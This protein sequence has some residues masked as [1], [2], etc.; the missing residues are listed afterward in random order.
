M[1]DVCR[2]RLG[3]ASCARDTPR[4]EAPTRATR[5][6][7][8]RLILMVQIQ[9]YRLKVRADKT[10]RCREL[11]MPSECRP[12]AVYLVEPTHFCHAGRSPFEVAADDTPRVLTG[13]TNQAMSAKHLSTRARRP[14]KSRCAV[15]HRR[16]TRQVGLSH[17]AD[18][19]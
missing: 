13:K 11:V 9:I 8:T 14:A 7:W 12:L 15:P 18:S 16:R 5:S 2:R 19:R 6:Q 3:P 4:L 17:Q 1:P 10:S